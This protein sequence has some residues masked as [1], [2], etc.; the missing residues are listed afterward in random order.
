VP[1]VSLVDAHILAELDEDRFSQALRPLFEDAGPLVSLLLGRRFGN[2]EELISTVQSLLRDADDDL[3]SGILRAHP[4]LGASPSEL[5]KTSELSWTEQGGERYPD[6]GV[7]ERLALINDEYERRF[8]FPPLE[9]VAGRPLADIVPVLEARLENDPTVELSAGC[10][11][12]VAIAR[13][14]L[15]KLTSPQEQPCP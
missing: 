15:K 2:W 1:E 7:D 4:R 5:R 11:A 13:D 14:R 12:L 6:A 10:D 3:R 8:G 9:F